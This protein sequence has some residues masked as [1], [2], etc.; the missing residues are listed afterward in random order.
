MSAT[1]PLSSETKYHTNYLGMNEF[2]L[3]TVDQDG[4]IVTIDGAIPFPS[5]IDSETAI[6]IWGREMPAPEHIPEFFKILYALS[7]PNGARAMFLRGGPGLGKSHMAY[8]LSR[9]IKGEDHQHIDLANRQLTDA[10]MLTAFDPAKP[11]TLYDQISDKYR[12]GTLT[13]IS[14]ALLE[15]VLGAPLPLDGE[16]K[17]N[18]NAALSEQANTDHAQQISSLVERIAKAEGLGN[19]ASGLSLRPEFGAIPRA[20]VRGGVV[21]LDEIGDI[22]PRSDKAIH[23]VLQY[24]RGERDEGSYED[25]N[26]TKIRLSRHTM[27]AGFFALF[28]GNS[29]DD[30]IST[31]DRSGSFQSRLPP[32]DLAPFG[33]LGWAHVFGQTFA[34]VPVNT[35]YQSHKA[36]WDAN[37]PEMFTHFLQYTRIRGLDESEV[38]KADLQLQ[39]LENPDA[40]LKAGTMFA[41][42]M[43]F[44][45]KALAKP[46]AI[47]AA[48]S[49]ELDI[50]YRKRGLPDRRWFRDLYTA[51]T[52][53]EP[54]TH[55]TSKATVIRG[56]DGLMAMM[57]PAKTSGGWEQQDVLTT[58]GTRI[59]AALVKAIK[60]KTADKPQ[61]Q[62]ALLGKAIDLG[63]VEAPVT[64][65]SNLSSPQ[66][67]ASKVT[68]ASLLNIKSSVG[69]SKL[70][71]AENIHS[72]IIAALTANAAEKAD[73]L[74]RIF[75]V[76]DVVHAMTACTAAGALLSFPADA[77]D[78]SLANPPLVALKVEQQG[79]DKAELENAATLEEFLNAF[80]LPHQ[81][82]I[83]S[84]LLFLP[85]KKT[86]MA[87]APKE[88]IAHG[89]GANELGA[90][91]VHVRQGNRLL[92][93]AI[94]KTADKLLIMGDLSADQNMIAALEKAGAEVVDFR[95][96]DD[97]VAVGDKIA[98]TIG[99]ANHTV[100]S[101]IHICEALNQHHIG[102]AYVDACDAG[103][104][105]NFGGVRNTT[106]SVVHMFRAT[107][108]EDPKHIKS[109]LVVCRSAANLII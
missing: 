60:A 21:A 3:P 49:T 69:R 38:S 104:L 5:T 16:K 65:G 26:G 39:L 61:L 27:P 46:E 14:S 83:Y 18:W 13:A 95:R 107:A 85:A 67:N 7:Q 29:S 37:S 6:G 90:T 89:V 97:V 12:E 31:Q 73:G 98:R 19:N 102:G 9:L 17:I 103:G 23:S 32:V 59:S 11:R 36:L 58:L 101:L 22:D 79:N 100:Q 96:D 20:Y 71:L 106:A 99:Q 81:A 42:L 33:S 15:S 109:R 82:R 40:V 88:A 41:D 55:N 66:P 10:M 62:A 86:W 57:A 84:Q 54:D 74:K 50:T 105:L 92:P 48:L 24:L 70:K 4:K 28:S 52:K 75:R 43:V 63:L 93:V 76:N 1:T 53:V 8:I 64:N 56:I 108:S 2:G 35:W 77:K 94:L 51:A 80:T 47:S 30:N 68:L 78:I 25:P 91:V 45:D 34:G 44:W 72:H 87:P